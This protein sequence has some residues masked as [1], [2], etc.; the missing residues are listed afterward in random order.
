MSYLKLGTI[1]GTHGLDGSIKFISSSY[2]LE[3]RLQAGK[4]IYLSNDGSTMQ[5]MEVC[6][7]KHMPKFAVVKL[8]E[9]DKIELAESFKS[10]DI[11]VKKDEL[12][13]DED[14]YYFSDLENCLV[15]DE[16]NNLLGKVNRVEEFPAQITLRV[17]K[18]DGKD[19]FVPFIDKFIINVN[20]QTKEIKIK[21]IEGML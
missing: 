4:N 12:A 20:I 17:K 7:F 16:N 21:V 11:F 8:K 9:I 18:D 2:F 13:L 5:K 14:T 19:F 1:I 6:E 10:F 3:E 15:Y